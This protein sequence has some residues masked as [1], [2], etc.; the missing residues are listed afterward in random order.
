MVFPYS[1]LHTPG[2]LEDEDRLYLKERLL[3]FIANENVRKLYKVDML[4]CAGTREDSQISSDSVQES[5]QQ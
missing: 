2:L 1:S 4:S 3:E 5:R